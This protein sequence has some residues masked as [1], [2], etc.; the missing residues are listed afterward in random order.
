MGR[1]L[2][3]LPLFAMLRR[4]ELATVQKMETSANISGVVYTDNADIAAE[5]DGARLSLTGS[6][7]I[8]I[9]RDSFVSIPAGW[10][11]YQFTNSNP[12]DSQNDFSL[13]IKTE[14]A[15]CLNM[16]KNIAL[17]DSSG[18]NYASGRLDF[19]SYDKY[20][21]VERADIELECLDR[22]FAAWFEEYSPGETLPAHYWFWDGREHVDP[23]K[24]AEAQRTRLESGTTT[25]AAEYARDGKDW[26]VEFEQLKREQ[27]YMISLGL[28]LPGFPSSSP[29]GQAPDASTGNEGENE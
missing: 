28:T 2:S 27:D 22:I 20:I 14:V 1:T 25:Y 21:D 11:L 12:T 6:E 4:Y 24:N 19:Q 29:A 23:L 26:Q 15:R 18:Y 9:N 7:D 10:K 16:P 8:E 5:V 13:M 3:A 17:G